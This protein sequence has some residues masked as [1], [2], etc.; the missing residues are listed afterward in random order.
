MPC[1]R[2]N[3]GNRYMFQTNEICITI[4]DLLWKLYSFPVFPSRMYTL[5]QTKLARKPFYPIVNCGEYFQGTRLLTFERRSLSHSFP[6]DE[7]LL[8]HKVAP[9]GSGVKLEKTRMLFTASC[10][11]CWHPGQPVPYF[12]AITVLKTADWRGAIL[13]QVYR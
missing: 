1:F 2:L 10:G 7:M 6:C 5:F 11:H 4:I 12:S 9:A 13:V 3:C 8:P